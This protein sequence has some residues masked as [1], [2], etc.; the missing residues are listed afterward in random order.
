MIIPVVTRDMIYLSKLKFLV[1]T[2][3]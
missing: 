3:T 2:D 1:S